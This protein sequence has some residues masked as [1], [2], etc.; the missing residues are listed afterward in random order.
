MAALKADSDGIND[1]SLGIK[2]GKLD[3]DGINDGSLGIKDGSLDSDGIINDG[4]LD[5]D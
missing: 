3:S 4:K 2:D 1:G 5:S